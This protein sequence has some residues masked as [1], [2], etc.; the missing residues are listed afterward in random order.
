MGWT[1]A[2]P[3]WLLKGPGLAVLAALGMWVAGVAWFHLPPALALPGTL[4]WAV[5]VVAA[6]WQVGR[7][8]SGSRRLALGVFVAGVMLAGFHW[9][10]LE[11]LQDRDWADDVARRLQVSRLDGPYVTLE[12][13]RNFHWRS[14]TDYQVSWEQ[15]NY[16]LRQLRSADLFLSYW[17]GPAIAHT[18]VSFGFS[19]GRHLVFSLEIRKERDESFDALAG[20]FRRYEMTL[21]A[22]EETDII[23]VRS[24]IRDEQVD[25]YRVA[26]LQGKALENLFLAYL[27]QA[28]ALD[29]AP[30]FYNTLTSNCTTIVWDM[31]RQVSPALPLD[32]RLLASGYFPGYVHDLGALV[33]GYDL[34][35]LQQAGRI[36]DRAL[37]ADAGQDF[38]Q[39]IRQG[40]PGMQTGAIQ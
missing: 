16:D 30:A 17:M 29:A 11:P 13:V 28:R 5:A 27:Q 26:A 21:V 6:L 32:W 23:R 14:E 40:V 39:A 31:A 1:V 37:A 20:F 10:R 36:T 35:T 8:T 22:S 15:R 24:N 38:S 9:W 19:D 12:N 7:G 3:K 2:L 18:L 33:P 25:V 34:A 4:L